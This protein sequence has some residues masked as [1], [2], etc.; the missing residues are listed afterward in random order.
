MASSL[1]SRLDNLE[2][3]VRAKTEQLEPSVYGVVDRVDKDGKIH[4]SRRW[5]GTIGNMVATDEEPTISI[6]S[7]LEPLIL[8]HKKVKGAFG[9]RGGAKSIGGMDIMSGEVNASGVSVFCL[10]ETMKSLSQSIFKGILG[11]VKA[12]GLKGFSPVESRWKIDHNSGGLFMFGGLLNV[13]DMKSLFEFKYFLLEEAA[14]TSQHALDTL[15]PTLRGVDGAEQ[16]MLWNPLSSNDPMSIEFINP[17]QAQIDRDGYYEDDYHLIIKVDYTDNPFFEHDSSLVEELGK[18]KAKLADGRMTQT[19]FNH[20]WHGAFN[21]DIENSVITGDWFDACI[22]AHIKLGI[23]IRGA[24]IAGCDPSDMGSDP[25]GYT[26]RQGIVVTGL[27]EIEAEN[28]NRKMDESCKL[29]IGYGVDSFGYDADGLGATLRDNVDRAFSGKTAKIY[30]YKGSSEIHDPEALFKSETAHLS[31]H[32]KNLKNKDVL[33]NKKAQ[34]IIGMAERIYN[35]YEAVALGKYK[36]PDDLISFATYDPETKLGIQPKMLK[37]LRAEACKTPIK[38]GSSTVRFYT[39]EELRRGIMIN[40]ARIIIP[41]P[42]LFDAV[43]LSFD[44]AGIISKVNT[45]DPS[46]INAKTVSHW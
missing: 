24:K 29:A 6:I 19:R 16:W 11:R 43:V 40:G 7:K 20:I 36:D 10:R 37:K 32:D 34:N 46:T 27:T 3:R 38:L 2:P 25:C 4:Y 30:A 12:I 31:N 13:E 23:D 21:D 8:K 9:G 42:N 17:Y 22:D 26:H 14:K 39:K 35:T 28:G 41:S 5:R 15:G 44:K 1:S 33:Y 45:I 18:D